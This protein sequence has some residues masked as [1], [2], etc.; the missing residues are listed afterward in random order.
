MFNTDIQKLEAGGHVFLFEVDGSEF[1]ADILRFHGYKIP[2][3]STDL[4]FPPSIQAKHIIWQGQT[5][6]AWPVQITGME[7]DS[8]GS[9]VTPVLSVGN[10]LGTISALCIEFQDM[11]QA[12]VIVHETMKKYLDAANF[13]GGNPTA[14]A[15]QELQHLWYVDSKSNEDMESVSWKLSSPADIQGKMIPG[16]QLAAYC[17]WAMTGKYRGAECTYA[18]SSMFDDNDLPTANPLLDMC[19]GTVNGC[20]IRF[21]SENPL[22]H[23]GFVAQQLIRR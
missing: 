18:G 3:D 14:D 11:L 22:P 1:G 21:G 12:K 10:V 23:G 17:H 19:S 7:A 6:E 16:R 9:P 4:I 15:T 8:S 20:T 2:L 5:Y 13:T